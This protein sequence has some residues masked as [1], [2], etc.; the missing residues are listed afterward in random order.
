MI[1]NTL[2]STPSLWKTARLLVAKGFA[3]H[4]GPDLVDEVQ[5]SPYPTRVRQKP[6][7]WLLHPCCTAP[8][9]HFRLCLNIKWTQKSLQAGKEKQ[10]LAWVCPWVPLKRTQGLL[11]DRNGARHHMVVLHVCSLLKPLWKV[12]L[13]AAQV[14]GHHLTALHGYL[15]SSL[16]PKCVASVRLA[17]SII[18][19]QICLCLNPSLGHAGNAVLHD[20]NEPS[21]PLRHNLLQVTYGPPTGA[22]PP[23]GAAAASNT[24]GRQ[25]TQTR[26]CLPEHRSNGVGA[27]PDYFAFQHDDMDFKSADDS[28]LEPSDTH[29]QDCPQSTPVTASAGTLPLLFSP[30]PSTGRPM[31]PLQQAF[32][33][34]Q[35]HSDCLAL[36]HRSQTIGPSPVGK[37][38]AATKQQQQ[39]QQAGTTAATDPRLSLRGGLHGSPIGQGLLRQ[40]RAPAMYAIGPPPF[41]QGSTG[42]QAPVPSP[43]PTPAS[44]QGSG[45]TVYQFQ[46]SSSTGGVQIS[47]ASQ[48]GDLHG[49]VAVHPPN[50]VTPTDLAPAL[51][52]HAAGAPPGTGPTLSQQQQQQ[53]HIVAKMKQCMAF[54]QKMQ[55]LL[56]TGTWRLPLPIVHG[57]LLLLS[58]TCKA[59]HGHFMCLLG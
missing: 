4:I 5:R 20:I 49:G 29:P 3:V 9:H 15:C 11:V 44:N 2:R 16:K 40:G 17:V 23:Q 26:G 59:A 51:Q 43:S 48:V 47:S 36:K 28:W 31:T 19:P 38:D 33:A 30:S 53:Q 35:R 8:Q 56:Y 24:F 1:I 25:S 6:V 21:S 50:S 37:H 34:A 58:L 46:G 13:L 45:G 54:I 57:H 18:M 32:T 12:F 10:V 42:F 41:S 39:Q 7:P 27:D 52:P 55:H 22:Q 14:T